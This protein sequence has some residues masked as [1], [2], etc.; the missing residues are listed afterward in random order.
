MK[1]ETLTQKIERVKKMKEQLTK[2]KILELTNICTRT[3]SGAH[4]TQCSKYWQEF[5]EL[6]LIKI[7]RPIHKSCDAEYHAQHWSLQITDDAQKVIDFLHELSMGLSI[8]KK[9]ACDER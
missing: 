6:G 1:D 2:E 9:E 4:F 3:K 7:T 5:E 8:V